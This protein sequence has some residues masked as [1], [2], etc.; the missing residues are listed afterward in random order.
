MT[1]RD[2]MVQ[3]RSKVRAQMGRFKCAQGCT[4]SPSLHPALCT[5]PQVQERAFFHTNAPINALAFRQLLKSLD[6]ADGR[7]LKLCR[8][9]VCTS[10]S[11]A[12][13]LCPQPY[14]SSK[15]ITYSCLRYCAIC[16]HA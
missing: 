4:F 9:Q 6:L 7:P 16:R 15:H 1:L 8:D 3:A 14:I 13:Q 11:R 2:A 10:K 12:S 5:S